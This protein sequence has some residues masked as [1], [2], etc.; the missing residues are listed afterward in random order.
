M[1]AIGSVASKKLLGR[2]GHH[3]FNRGG[4]T[5]GVIGKFTRHKVSLVNRDGF[6]RRMRGDIHITP[7]DLNLVG[8]GDN[9]GGYDQQYTKG[10]EDSLFRYDTK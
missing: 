9:W 5:C 7:C 3:H 2:V 4:N 1:F 6:V 8:S 10:Y